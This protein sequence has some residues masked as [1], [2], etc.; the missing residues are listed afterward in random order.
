[1]KTITY[2]EL[3]SKALLELSRERY[4]L[5]YVLDYPIDHHD[6]EV[7]SARIDELQEWLDNE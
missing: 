1:M 3:V 6:V 4:S 2:R 7:V 5:V